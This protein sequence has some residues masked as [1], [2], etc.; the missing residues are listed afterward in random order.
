MRFKTIHLTEFNVISFCQICFEYK[1]YLNSFVQRD[2][3]LILNCFNVIKC[4]P[5]VYVFNTNCKQKKKLSIRSLINS[6]AI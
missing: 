1:R 2:F 5:S 3:N 6:K 4:D